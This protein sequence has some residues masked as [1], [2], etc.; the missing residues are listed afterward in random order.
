M[1]YFSTTLNA[2]SRDAN[3][4]AMVVTQALQFEQ[5]QTRVEAVGTAD[6]FKSVDLFPAAADKVTVI[7]FVAGQLVSKDSVLIELDNRRQVVAM[8]R[9][10]ISLRDAERTLQRLLES[11]KLGAVTESA[12]DDART[13]RDLAAAAVLGATADLQDRRLLAPFTGIVG[14]TDVEVGDRIT[15]QT[16]V[17]TIDARDKLFINFSAPENALDMLSKNTV[18]TVQ[19]WTDREKVLTANVAEIDS[20]VNEVDRTLRARA[21]LDNTDD[22]YRPGMS[23]RVALQVGGEEYAAIPEAALSWGG[24][25]AYVWLAT[26]GNAKKVPVQVKQRLRGRILVAG[27]L[28]RDDEL[29]IEGIQ[30]LREGQSVSSELNPVAQR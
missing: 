17:T 28:L 19:P 30:R 14:L 15:L 21:L 5:Q 16:M 12:L 7:N 24:T 26:E 13:V 27:A 3:R 18:V 4:P 29:I 9:A 2:Q 20:R 6:A 1:L 8:R 22:A 10:E 23:F 11:K 25:G